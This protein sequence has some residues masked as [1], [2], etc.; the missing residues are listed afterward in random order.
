M[1]TMNCFVKYFFLTL[2][3]VLVL[4]VQA[5]TLRNQLKRHPSA[6]L[7]LHG[8]DPVA[9]QKW[10][11]AVMQR[12]RRENKLVYLSIGYFSCHWCHV[13]QRE[14][15]KNPRI[16]RYINRSEEHTSELQSH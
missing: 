8:S 1:M 4:P 9:W 13:M 5:A 14:T 16:A 12:A 3:C 6:Y 15:Y 11:P 7:A 10:S 2:I